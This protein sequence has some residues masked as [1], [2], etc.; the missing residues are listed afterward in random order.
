M[1]MEMSLPDPSPV[2]QDPAILGFVGRK[3]MQFALSG[4]DGKLRTETIRSYDANVT[5]GVAGAL[6]SFQHELAMNAFPIRASIAVAGLVRGDVIAVTRTRW[7]LSRSGLQ[8]MLGEPPLLLNDFAAEAWALNS[9]DARAPEVLGGSTKLT[10]RRPGT[11]LVL[12]VTSG[13][14]A[15]VVNQSEAGVVTVLATEAGHGMFAPATQELTQLAAEL[16]PSRY[17]VL[18]EDVVSAPALLAIYDLVAARS[19]SRTGARTPEEVAGSI[20]TDTVARQACELFSRAFW[21]HAGSLVVTYGAWDGVLVTGSL[22][23]ALKPILRR[24]DVQAPFL[25]I[26]P[27]Q[28]Y[29]DLVPRGFV[30]PVNGELVGAAEALRHTVSN[31]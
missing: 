5:T 14:G 20:A 19:K 24:P 2:M 26:T 17:P 7:F 21:S 15:A 6:S 3:E 31:Q 4:P 10:L 1:R 9:P 25:A 30:L 11:Y 13:L 29:L 27:Y 22:L 16:A 18:A 23:T 12:G 28:R 8:A